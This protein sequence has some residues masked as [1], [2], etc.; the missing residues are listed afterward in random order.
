MGLSVRYAPKWV[1]EGRRIR[2]LVEAEGR[3]SVEIPSELE[4]IDRTPLDSVGPDHRLYMRGIS[5]AKSAR[6]VLSSGGT[7]IEL[8]IE[9]I[10]EADWEAP[11]TFGSVETP[12]IWPSVANTL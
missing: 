3:V 8:Q 11:R 12:R 1:G 9:V 6:I 10:P 4:L 2:I 7:K 5:A